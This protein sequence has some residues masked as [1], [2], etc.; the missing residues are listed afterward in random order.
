MSRKPTQ[1]TAKAACDR[2]FSQ[3][4]RSLGFCEYCGRGEPEVQLQCAHW[5]SRRYSNTRCDPENAFCLCAGCHL[6]FTHNPTE[7][8]DW[9]V[10]Q[11]GRAVY[12]RLREAANQ[13]A[14]VDWVKEREVLK[15]MLVKLEEEAIL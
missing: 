7:F 9:A 4:I 5:I 13:T 11:R 15:Q 12:E 1:K 6:R 8:S 2:L 14:K 3:Y 10:K